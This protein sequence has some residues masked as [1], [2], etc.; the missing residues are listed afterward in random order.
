VAA[1]PERDGPHRV[2]PPVRRTGRLAS[3]EQA[4]G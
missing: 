1:T 4:F 3:V 2:L